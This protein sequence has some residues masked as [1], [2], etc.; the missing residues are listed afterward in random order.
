MRHGPR[1]SQR[2]AALAKAQSSGGVERGKQDG[3]NKAR[4]F[5]LGPDRAAVIHP[6]K[7]WNFLTV[8]AGFFL[9][10][11]RER[12][13]AAYQLLAELDGGVLVAGLPALGAAAVHADALEPGPPLAG[14]AVHPRL[15][16][17]RRGDPGRTGS[18][19]ALLGH[20][21]VH[22][23][24][25]ARCW[26]WEL[27]IDALLVRRGGGGTAEGGRAVLFG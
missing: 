13:P 3:S 1:L 22:C 5:D 23:H 11:G 20:S 14:D 25:R 19:A 27:V 6:R 16:C 4:D 2:P 9:R 10:R 18:A 12:G 7:D 17:G 15:R 21:R 24:R 8:K 26:G